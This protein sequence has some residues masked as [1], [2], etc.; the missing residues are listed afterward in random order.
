MRPYDAVPVVGL[1]DDRWALVV[2]VLAVVMF[3]CGY[4][5]AER[6]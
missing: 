5:I 1:T 6:W 2:L 4:L 3:T